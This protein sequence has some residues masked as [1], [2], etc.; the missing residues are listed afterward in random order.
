VVVTADAV[1]DHVVTALDIGADDYVIKPFSIRELLARI[2]VAMRHR[3]MTAVPDDD[4][5]MCGDLR[6]DV[7]GHVVTV[8][9]EEIELQARPFAALTLLVRNEGRVVT[10]SRISEALGGSRGGAPDAN[11]LR[12]M[13]SKIR[14]Q[15]GTGPNRPQIHTETKVGYRL[16][17]PD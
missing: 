11:G 6:I 13:L 15:L 16:V 4:L 3:A 5:L 8:A 1:E 9:G 10:Y 14:K 2:R 12:I 17:R 7:A